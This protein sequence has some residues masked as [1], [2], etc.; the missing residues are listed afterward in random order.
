[1][2]LL[3]KT[4]GVEHAGDDLQIPVLKSRVLC[5]EEILP[6]RRCQ[7]PSIDIRMYL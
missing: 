7:H 4:V 3:F 2:L 6:T 1:M 5:M